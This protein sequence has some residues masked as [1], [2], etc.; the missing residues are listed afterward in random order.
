MIIIIMMMIIIIIIIIISITII[1][2]IIIVVVII[3]III[4]QAWTNTDETSAGAGMA[5]DPFGENS[6]RLRLPGRGLW[7]TSPCVWEMSTPRNQNPLM[8]DPRTPDSDPAGWANSG[9]CRVLAT[10]VSSLYAPGVS[11][12]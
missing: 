6:R 3:I 12:G 2:V 4:M 10:G 11:R 1:I 8:S 5:A 9:V 7:G